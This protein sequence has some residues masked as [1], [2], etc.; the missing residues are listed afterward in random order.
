MDRQPTLA[1]PRT[2]DESTPLGHTEEP[3]RSFLDRPTAPDGTPLGIVYGVGRVIENLLVKKADI[4]KGRKAYTELDASLAREFASEENPRPDITDSMR[5]EAFAK[6]QATQRAE[7]T[8]WFDYLDKNSNYDNDFKLYVWKSVTTT[9]I[10]EG[11]NTLKPL[12][13]T[14]TIAHFPKLNPEALAYIYDVYKNRNS[15]NPRPDRIR[16]SKLKSAPFHVLYGAALSLAE[17]DMTREQHRITQILKSSDGS[18]ETFNFNPDR[19]P[20]PDNINPGLAARVRDYHVTQ[21]PVDI[22]RDLSESLYNHHTGWDIA[23]RELSETYLRDGDQVLIYYAE[24]RKGRGGADRIPRV[25][26]RIHDG[27]VADVMINDKL[28]LGAG[29]VSDNPGIVRASRELVDSVIEQLEGLDGGEEFISRLEALRRLA[30]IRD[31]ANLPN[32]AAGLEADDLR[33]LYELGENIPRLDDGADRLISQARQAH[34]DN[35]WDTDQPELARLYQ[36]FIG[37]QV[38]SSLDAYE[39]VLSEIYDRRSGNPR[40]YRRLGRAAVRL[41]ANVDRAFQVSLLDAFNAQNQEWIENGVYDYMVDQLQRGV[42][43]S[44]VGTPRDLRIKLAD[45]DYLARNFNPAL[46]HVD[47]EAFGDDG[48][49]ALYTDDEWSGRIGEFPIHYSLIAESFDSE[50]SYKTIGQQR[51]LLGQRAEEN[52]DLHIRVP[53]VMTALVYW[54]ALRTR[55][56]DLSNGAYDLTYIN[57]FNLPSKMGGGHT[58]AVP[59]SYIDNDGMVVVRAS[60]RPSPYSLHQARIEIG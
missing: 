15:S 16:L 18:W 4:V 23:S 9:S 55:G 32:Q 35:M 30:A 50:L 24:F 39:E 8:E 40:W 11:G 38:E 29:L 26:I 52:P 37:D 51:E 60:E 46:H 6:I 31:F 1:L 21:A 48:M 54:R 20:V 17:A 33:F 7:L 36:E 5:Q 19:P 42:R 44:L 49:Q 41:F 47:L 22:S 56:V 57:H 28:G 2:G 59:A 12:R 25:A 58:R 13:T 27:A 45:I 14:G 3:Y 34:I 53:S 43:Y 10:E